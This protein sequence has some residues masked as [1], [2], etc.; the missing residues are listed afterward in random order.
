M[1]F[2]LDASVALS[3]LF[4]DELAD[5]EQATLASLRAIEQDSALVPAFWPLEVANGLHRAERRSRVTNA[6]VIAFRSRLAVLSIRMDELTADYA[7]G[8]LIGVARRYNLSVYDASYLD[9]AMRDG[10]PLATLDR[11]LERAARE[12]GVELLA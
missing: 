2:V 5:A 12:A 4:E 10:L 6:D 9:L 7:L 3:W 1:P 11:A 8:P